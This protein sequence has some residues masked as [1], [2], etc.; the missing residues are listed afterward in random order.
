[1]TS[2]SPAGNTAHELDTHAAQESIDAIGNRAEAPLRHPAPRTPHTTAVHGALVVV[3]QKSLRD[4]IADDHTRLK[5]QDVDVRD[6][7]T[8]LRA[9]HH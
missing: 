2:C 5:Y 4:R 7:A 1:M 9:H 3:D 8:M 6:T